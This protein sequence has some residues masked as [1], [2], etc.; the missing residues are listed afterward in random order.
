MYAIEVVSG[1]F[2]GLPIVKQHKLVKDVISVR[3]APALPAGSDH[4]SL[5]SLF[6]TRRSE[7]RRDVAGPL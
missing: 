2:K 6:G 5:G 1:A 4:F 7:R 3:K